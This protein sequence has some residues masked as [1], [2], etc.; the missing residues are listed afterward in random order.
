EVPGF[1]EG[2]LSDVQDASL[3]RVAL[4]LERLRNVGW[5]R[6][7]CPSNLCSQAVRFVS[8]KG[9]RKLVHLQREAMRLLPHDEI[10]KP[11]CWLPLLHHP[12]C[13]LNSVSCLLSPVS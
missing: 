2:T 3:V 1:F 6:N 10:L 11:S 5:H 7:R 8:R 4:L 13:L 12:P 9:R